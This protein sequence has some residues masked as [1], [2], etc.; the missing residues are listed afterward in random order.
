MQFN[1]PALL[2]ILNLYGFLF[3]KYPQFN[4]RKPFSYLHLGQKRTNMERFLKRLTLYLAA[5]KSI[6]FLIIFW[7]FLCDLSHRLVVFQFLLRYL[8][9][10]LSFSLS[11]FLSRC[12][13]KLL[14]CYF[15][16]SQLFLSMCSYLYSHIYQGEYYSESFY[17]PLMKVNMLD[18]SLELGI[19]LWV[20]HR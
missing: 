15:V 1:I 12:W 17:A 19:Q 6:L 4:I 8:S 5:T 11:L 14:E 2:C 18:F 3:V 16:L 13:S 10:S 9:F 20:L 7:K